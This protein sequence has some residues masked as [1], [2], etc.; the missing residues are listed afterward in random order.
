MPIRPTEKIKVL[1]RVPDQYLS[2][3]SIFK[4]E[5]LPMEQKRKPSPWDEIQ[6][7]TFELSKKSEKIVNA[8]KT[9]AREVDN[10]EGK[11]YNV[12]LKKE[13]SRI[14]NFVPTLSELVENNGFT[15]DETKSDLI[16]I[17]ISGSGPESSEYR[18]IYVEINQG[19]E[20][21]HL[22]CRFDEFRDSDFTT[23]NTMYLY[24]HFSTFVSA[25]NQGAVICEPVSDPDIDWEAFLREYIH[26]PSAVIEHT[27]GR[28]KSPEPNEEL[29]RQI[30][31]ADTDSIKSPDTLD[32]ENWRV[33]S[34]EFKKLADEKK[35]E[36]KD[37]VGD[38]V[39]ANMEDTLHKIN[40]LESMYDHLLDKLGIK[41]IIRAAMK[42]LAIDLPIEE[43]KAFLRQINAFLGDILAILEIPTITLDDLIPTVDIMSGI[44]EQ[45]IMAVAEAVKKALTDMVKQ[46]IIEL[47]ENCGDVSKASFGGVPIGE[48]FKNGGIGGL[49]DATSGI[50][51][52]AALG[53][54]LAGV[55]TGLRQTGAM[56][57]NAKK[58]LLN[59]NTFISNDTLQQLTSENF[60]AVGQ[61]IDQVS[62]VLTPGELS[63][64]LRGQAPDSV[65]K[66]IKNVAESYAGSQE[67]PPSAEIVKDLLA[68]PEKI[69]DFFLNV[70]KVIDEPAI[71]KT[72]RRF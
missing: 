38:T 52:D 10:F 11:V 12:D 70:A 2:G 3:S 22:I 14:A 13:A 51:G 48:A 69:N 39:L 55:K 23:S 7:N 63:R 17:G 66:I 46:I 16:M 24:K 45:L 59:L 54:A 4:F 71:L 50:L 25:S 30:R 56:P 20:F 64:V 43:I 72:D 28:P 18:P 44:A 32:Q 31:A 26:F 62:A 42:C 60:A 1:V 68:S 61:I 8:L 29:E 67:A 37:F 9:Y 49:V 5:D 58:F 40:K 57:T 35:K 34:Q 27:K 53:G 21:K 47:L 19:E 65:V 15:F 33:A 41:Y 6:L 36:A